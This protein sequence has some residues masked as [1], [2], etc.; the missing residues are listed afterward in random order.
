M[1]NGILM[2]KYR[3]SDE[4]A[5]NTWSVLYQ[6]VVPKCWPSIS[7]DVAKFCKSC[8][9]CQLVDKPNQIIPPA[10]LEPIPVMNDPFSKVI[11]DCVGPMPKTTPGNHF[12]LTI[13]CC[14]TRY[15]EAIPLRSI[16]AKTVVPALIKFF[17]ILGFP[18]VLQSDQGSNF[19]SKLF[20]NVMN[21]RG[22]MQQFSTIY[23]PESQG[24]LERFHQTLKCMLTKF[25]KENNKDWD[26]SVPFVLYAARSVC[27]PTD[28]L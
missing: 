19:T 5:C 10:P 20:K 8:A 13:M 7:S 12:L 4:P 3:P 18:K 16:S 1:K 25:C 6:L 28:M 11:I 9:I 27:G 17:T 24:A 2:C 21:D 15:P 23:H 22:A 26:D 14:S